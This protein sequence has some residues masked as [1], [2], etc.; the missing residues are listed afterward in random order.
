MANEEVLQLRF[1]NESKKFSHYGRE[2]RE[3]KTFK[4]NCMRKSLQDYIIRSETE[5][6]YQKKTAMRRDQKVKIRQKELVPNGQK[7][8]NWYVGGY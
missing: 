1:T 4:R 3:H 6:R 5:Q 8:G 2:N 7:K